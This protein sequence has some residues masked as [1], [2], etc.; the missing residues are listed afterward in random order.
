MMSTTRFATTTN[1]AARIA[2]PMMIG[3]SCTVIAWTM[4]HPS[5]GMPKIVSVMITPPSAVPMS[6]PASVT[7]GVS[8]ERS[9]CTAMRR[10]SDMPLDLAV[11]I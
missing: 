2:M 9:P 3:R 5:P 6:R 8:A 11:R 1:V 4:F 7:T 10:R